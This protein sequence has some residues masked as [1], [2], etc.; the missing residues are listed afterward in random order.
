MFFK[1]SP[2]RGHI[3][4]SVVQTIRT[5]TDVKHKKALYL[6]RL[7]N[8]TPEARSV[9]ERKI[10]E[11]GDT[12]LSLKFY[13]LLSIYGYEEDLVP[14]ASL[15]ISDVQDYGDV[16]V[17]HCIWEKLGISEII[18]R[19]GLR[20]GGKVP[21]GKLA[22]IQVIHRNCDPGS[23]EKTARWY[24]KTALPIVLKVPPTR[25]YS[26]LLLRSLEYLQPKYTVQMQ[27]EI[28]NRIR[29]TV[30]IQPSRVDIDTTAVHFEGNKC[31]I[32]KFGWSPPDQ[33]GKRQI[34]VSVAVDQNGIP[35]THIVFPGNKP[36]MK[37]LK[38]MDR[39]LRN[40]FGVEKAMRVGDR[41]IATKE[42]RTYMDRRKEPYLLALDL[43]NHECDIAEE[44]FAHAHWI[45]VDKEVRVAEVLKRENGRDMKYLV[46][47]NKVNAKKEHRERIARIEEAEQDLE[48]VQKS[49]AKGKITSRKQR[50]LRIGH[51]QMSLGVK[52]YIECR[53]KRKG[54]GFESIRMK[55]EIEEAERWDGV[56]VLVT[57][58][59]ELTPVE[60]LESYRE[61]DRVEKAICVL[62]S[63]LEIEPEYV[64]TKK[65]VL[66]HVF[67]CVLAC[68]LRAVMR[69]LLKEK[70]LDMSID[71]ALGILE[72]LKVASI[73]FKGDEARVHRKLTRVDG[74]T[75]TLM[76]V[77]I[78]RNA[79]RSLI[80]D[81]I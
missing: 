52:K 41:G 9:I 8:L 36:C 66:G 38:R 4:Y 54:Y 5:G 51:V 6:G 20:V 22:E 58:E 7:D 23:R 11:F 40:E 14:I 24:S 21:L 42:N 33:R 79:D 81:G 67:I 2:S 1:E 46:G 80:E 32:A 28:Y 72:R 73:S 53:G 50:D 31:V 69:H 49:V 68:Q 64:H 63:V 34:V 26:R 17:Q 48:A 65:H 71:E 12:R 76:E 13:K 44:A 37:T 43:D 70:G 18:D 56:F 10:K 74:R 57:T 29:E 27:R 77:F 35:L 62:K 75:R 30:G 61:R 47:M 60:M 19:I 25:V 39:I 55:E 78:L 59:M 15:E 16:I 3:Y 45:D